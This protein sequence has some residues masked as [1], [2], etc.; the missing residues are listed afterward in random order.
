M[1]KQST[2]FTTLYCKMRDRM[3]IAIEDAREISY[4]CPVKH[5]AAGQI[6][7]QVDVGGQDEVL[8][9]IFGI[10]A[11]QHQVLSRGDL[12]RIVRLSRTA[13][14]LGVCM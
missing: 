10:L 12:V 2:T 6:R 1:A 13:T 14:V 4:D 3:T 8:V 9:V 5:L 7:I 11:Q